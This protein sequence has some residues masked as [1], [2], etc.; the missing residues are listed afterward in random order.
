MSQKAGG[1]DERGE[2]AVGAHEVRQAL[3]GGSIAEQSFAPVELRGVDAAFGC[4]SAAP[5]GPSTP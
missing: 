3:A 5:T 1:A 2:K 4:T